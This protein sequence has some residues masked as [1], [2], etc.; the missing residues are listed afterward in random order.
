VARLGG[1]NDEAACLRLEK[2][3]IANV[4]VQLARVFADQLVAFAELESVCESLCD[5]EEDGEEEEGSDT[6]AAGSGFQN[7]ALIDSMLGI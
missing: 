1:L 2:F 7:I 4:T 6:W 3:E 5:K